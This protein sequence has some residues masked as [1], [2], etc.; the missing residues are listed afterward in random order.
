MTLKCGI[1]SRNPRE[2]LLKFPSRSAAR[3]VPPVLV[4]GLFTKLVP[5]TML[6]RV[7]SWVNGDGDRSM[8]LYP[9]FSW[10]RPLIQTSA[11]SIW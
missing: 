8:N 4:T 3:P 5:N 1:S 7:L 11:F 10:W 9:N 6:L 2:A